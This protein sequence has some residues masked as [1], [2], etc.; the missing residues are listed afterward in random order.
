MAIKIC[1]TDTS[2]K[3]TGKTIMTINDQDF[4]I[5]DCK[6]YGYTDTKIRAYHDDILNISFIGSDY[7]KLP[8]VKR[9]VIAYETI[10]SDLEDVNVVSFEG[11]AYSKA[12][13]ANS[14]NSRG[15]MQLAE[16]IGTLKYL[17]HTRNKSFI[18]YPSTTV[19]K[20]A[21]GNGNADK[22]LMQKQLK[23]DYP[24]FHH[25]YFDNILKWENPCSDIVDSFWMCE[26]LRLHMKY[27]VLGESKLTEVELHQVTS[28]TPASEPIIATQIITP[29][30]R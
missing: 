17:L 24:Q 15:M 30:G 16:F 22:L 7:S 11:Y 9:Q 4:S 21:T 27:D 14:S 12:R 2:I 19:K 5:I 29:H 18:V 10:L 20:F 6:Y 28:H 8:I 1:G 26:C 23:H 13:T 3:S 25:D